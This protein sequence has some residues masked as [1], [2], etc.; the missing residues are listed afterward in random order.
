M[1]LDVQLARRLFFH[2]AIADFFR[3]IRGGCHMGAFTLS[4]CA[5]DA[6]AYLRNPLPGAG[7]ATNFKQWVQHW[8]VPLNKECKPEV[9]YAVRC[10]LVHTYGLSDAM[11]KCG[12]T[13]VRYAHNEPAFHWKQ[14]AP[15]YYVLSLDRLVAE[16]SL[17]AFGFFDDLGSLCQGD[18]AFERELKARL[19]SLNLIT[20]TEILQRDGQPPTVKVEVEAPA[21]YSGMDSALSVFD[22]EFPPDVNTVAGEIQRIYSTR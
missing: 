11:R 22:E 16:V 3:A 9:L 7:T 15:G 6:M 4:V 18:P 1:S 20:R 10:G 17:A 21:R 12:M 14:Q 13:G 5:I 2:M 8:L 19:S